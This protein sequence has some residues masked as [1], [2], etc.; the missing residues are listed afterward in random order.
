MNKT[1][2]AGVYSE[3]ANGH[4][5]GRFT[6]VSNV[7]KIMNLPGKIKRSGIVRNDGNN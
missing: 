6:G 1:F 2:V 4:G 5:V 3:K 7:E